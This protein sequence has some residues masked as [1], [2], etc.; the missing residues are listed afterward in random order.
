MTR[1]MERWVQSEVSMDPDPPVGTV[2]TVGTPVPEIIIEMY[3]D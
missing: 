2:G 1:W 3:R